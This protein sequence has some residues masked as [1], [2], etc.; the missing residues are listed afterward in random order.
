MLLGTA[1]G[2]ALGLPAEGLTRSRIQPRWHGEWR[3]RF[4]FGHGMCS[5]DTDTVG[6]I[7]GA[8]AGASA[9]RQLI[10]AEWLNGI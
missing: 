7:V 6:A 3:H 4:V 2:D 10:P 8:L 9:G 5:G 1:V